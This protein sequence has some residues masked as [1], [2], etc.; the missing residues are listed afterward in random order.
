MN[1]SIRTEVNHRRK[2]GESIHIGTWLFCPKL[3]NLLH[4]PHWQGPWP[5]GQSI[6]RGSSQFSSNC[7]QGTHSNPCSRSSRGAA[8]PPQP[9]G[10]TS[11]VA[12]NYKPNF[13]SYAPNTS[14]R[15]GG[16]RHPDFM[17]KNTE[18]PKKYSGQSAAYLTK[19]IRLSNSVLE[20][21]NIIKPHIQDST[22]ALSQNCSPNTLQLAASNRTL[23]PTE[24]LSSQHEIDA[25]TP[26]RVMDAIAT[27]AA[28]SRLAILVQESRLL[29][30]SRRQAVHPNP[31]NMECRRRMEYGK[32]PGNS[33]QSLEDNII[34][35]LVALTSVHAD[36][37]RSDSAA[38][39]VWGFAKMGKS[40]PLELLDRLLAAFTRG[41]QQCIISGRFPKMLAM[42]MWGAAKMSED[43]DTLS[44]MAVQLTNSPTLKP[45]YLY[46]WT[47]LIEAC[48][49][50][51][52]HLSCRELVNCI[53]AVAQMRS[54]GVREGGL[55]GEAD[56]VVETMLHRCCSQVQD[57]NTQDVSNL[58]WSLAHLDKSPALQNL[59]SM[60]RQQCV[61]L[62]PLMLPKQQVCC[63]WGLWRS[64]EGGIMDLVIKIALSSS[65]KG[66]AFS[67]FGVQELVMLVYCIAKLQVT[68][69]QRYAWCQSLLA[70][71]PKLS[72]LVKEL[73]PSNL[74]KVAWAYGRLARKAGQD[75]ASAQLRHD[76]TLTLLGPLFNSLAE[77]VVDHGAA[78]MSPQSC[79]MTSWGLAQVGFYY[80]GAVAALTSQFE[81]QLSSTSNSSAVMMLAA[82][83]KISG[84]DQHR[85]MTNCE[86]G[87]DPAS[88]SS[89]MSLCSALI[90]RLHSSLSRL[91]SHD[92]SI[93]LASC[94]DLGV[95]DYSLFDSA[96]AEL[97]RR[98]KTSKQRH[99]VAKH[100][101]LNART[102]TQYRDQGTTLGSSSDEASD[103]GEKGRPINILAELGDLKGKFRAL[104]RNQLYRQRSRALRL[105][106][107]PS[108]ASFRTGGSNNSEPDNTPL[109]RKMRPLELAKVAWAYA[110]VSHVD[111]GLYEEVKNRFVYLARLDLRTE[112]AARKASMQS[113][114]TLYFDPAI[115]HLRMPSLSRGFWA[116]AM[117]GQHDASLFKLL[118][119][120]TAALLMTSAEPRD[121]AS[122]MWALSST[123]HDAGTEQLVQ[124][125]LGHAS[126]HVSHYSGPQMAIVLSSYAEIKVSGLLEDDGDLGDGDGIS[127]LRNSSGSS[128][129]GNL[130]Q[131]VLVMLKKMCCSLVQEPR[132]FRFY[133]ACKAVLAMAHL[134]CYNKSALSAAC[135]VA[136]SE[137]AKPTHAGGSSEALEVEHC[138][139]VAS[140][141]HALQLLSHSDF[142][143]ISSAA[144]FLKPNLDLLTMEELIS[145]TWSLSVSLLSECNTLHTLRSSIGGADS[146][147][148]LSKDA[149]AHILSLLEVLSTMLRE[150]VPA[151]RPLDITPQEL[152][153]LW[154][155]HACC[156][157]TACFH[158]NMELTLG[159]PQDA[160]R[161][162]C[163]TGSREEKFERDSKAHILLTPSLSNGFQLHSKLIETG[164]QA[165]HL[166]VG[167]MSLSRRRLLSDLVQLLKDLGCLEVCSSAAATHQG[168]LFHNSSTPSDVGELALRV[169]S[170]KAVEACLLGRR[171]VVSMRLP[172]VGG[173]EMTKIVIL[174]A[175]RS[176]FIQHR[177]DLLSSPQ[178][179]SSHRSALSSKLV[180]GLQHESVSFSPVGH[181]TADKRLSAQLL[182]GVGWTC[183]VLCVE[184]YQGIGSR[185]DKLSYLKS[186]LKI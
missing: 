183:K 20:L 144:I 56:H 148:R 163:S 15:D 153:M 186:L 132:I 48:G 51:V 29:E 119:Q 18:P 35:G 40:L 166:G 44:A 94:A 2:D 30:N 175:D 169:D 4:M 106:F 65:V 126:I 10:R 137:V 158:D 39:V 101:V 155:S 182:T 134:Q 33:S 174:L 88:T 116:F 168:T 173:S 78:A 167:P 157:V 90:P 179:D 140:F 136:R 171:D 125:C 121:V 89:T 1:L 185:K 55:A 110:K 96:A 69:D 115:Y 184:Q 11:Q 159:L 149:R 181:L 150:A 170:C 45:L 64:G 25:Q 53:W 9:E 87:L 138:S 81:A 133:D 66:L 63:V 13:K 107:G 8:S 58:C 21:H 77:G 100:T 160:I 28:V 36:S 37:F 70:A 68:S 24:S 102:D 152:V 82:L 5:A 180:L 118:A 75:G 147:D 113:K 97:T 59:S 114:Q 74:A 32:R 131:P 83:A 27:S 109:V 112:R 76:S 43:G 84:H 6:F 104:R 73:T 108:D 26:L 98:R 142:L 156:Q 93:M 130:H 124:K 139:T 162:T 17:S 172:S 178:L 22:A 62:L 34:L 141:I 54:T 161:G 146:T 31:S 129:A 128:T 151:H 103:V 135:E 176:S 105:L 92:M 67:R 23:L 127:V 177:D 86:E 123:G 3:S 120:R 52:T 41:Q 61:T 38:N 143:L 19:C 49:L 122:V 145:I 80:K 79:A 165:M 95:Y 85:E 46:H 91:G 42:M 72:T 7:I 57:M 99:A 154:Q 47:A 50:H 111:E 117:Q 71:A 14:V 16:K 60:L 164:E 12:K